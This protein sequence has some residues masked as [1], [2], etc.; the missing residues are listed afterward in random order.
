MRYMHPSPSAKSAAIDLLNAE[1]RG[2]VGETQKSKG[3][4]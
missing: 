1:V 4:A 3:G 2:D